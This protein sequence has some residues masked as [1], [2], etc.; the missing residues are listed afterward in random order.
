MSPGRNPASVPRHHRPAPG[1]AVVTRRRPVP[2]P[3]AGS[4]ALQVGYLAWTRRKPLPG[5]PPP[6]LH[7]P[8]TESTGCPGSGPA[9]TRGNHP[10]LPSSP[11]SHP[12]PP[13][14]GSAQRATSAK[15]SASPRPPPQHVR[16]MCEALVEAPA[17]EQNKK[18]CPALGLWATTSLVGATSSGPL[19]CHTAPRIPPR[20]EGDPGQRLP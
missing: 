16:S 18:P 17:P 20:E 10:P 3:S 6:Y 12:G 11:T 13:P 5:A 15:D 4:R 9:G 2:I 8:F 7:P 14:P 1:A 19:P